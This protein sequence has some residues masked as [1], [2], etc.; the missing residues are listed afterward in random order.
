MRYDERSSSVVGRSLGKGV[1]LELSFPGANPHPRIEPFDR[2]DT[3]V[4]YFIGNDPDQWH[5]DV[6]VWGGVRYVNLCPGIDLVVGAGLAPAEGR[7]QGSPLP[8]RLE[9][10]E[11]SERHQPQPDYPVRPLRQR[12]QGNV[13]HKV[14]PFLGFRSV[15]DKQQFLNELPDSC[16]LMHQKYAPQMSPGGVVGSQMIRHPGAVQ[17]DQQSSGML[18]EHQ[19]IGIQRAKRWR[20]RV[21]NAKDIHAGFASQQSPLQKQGASSRPGGIAPSCLGSLCLSHLS[22]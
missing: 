22:P 9:V 19:P 8:W 7:P 12:L 1:N 14:N 16:V 10:R 15:P 5:S 18:R 13:S 17:C 3:V 4:S 2:L 6:P 11:G 21:T 20:L